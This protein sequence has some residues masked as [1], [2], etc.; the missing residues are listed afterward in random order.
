M[1]TQSVSLSISLSSP[2][3][4]TSEALLGGGAARARGP[5]QRAHRPEGGRRLRAEVARGEDW[6][7]RGRCRGG[8]GSC[9]F[10]WVIQISL[11]LMLY[12]YM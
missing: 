7:G 4:R 10:V 6:G 9:L 12:T 3:S 5:R 2:L 1:T 11:L 8:A